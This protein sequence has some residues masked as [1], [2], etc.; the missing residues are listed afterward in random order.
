MFAKYFFASLFLD[1]LFNCCFRSMINLKLLPNICS[2]LQFHYPL[3]T[4]QW[5]IRPSSFYIIVIRNDYGCWVSW[6]WRIYFAYLRDSLLRNKE[7][8]LMPYYNIQIKFNYVQVQMIFYSTP[9]MTFLPIIIA[10][11]SHRN[12]VSTWFK[13]PPFR[14]LQLYMLFEGCRSHYELTDQFSR[15]SDKI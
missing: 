10:F 12:F 9:Y 2:A 15:E 3:L 13:R 1:S 11:N 4:T 14:R 7:I 8:L 5:S 6:T